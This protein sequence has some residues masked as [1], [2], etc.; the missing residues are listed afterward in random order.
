MII[1]KGDT[2]EVIEAKMRSA[3][4]WQ[5]V[6]NA[7]ADMR[8]KVETIRSLGLDPDKLGVDIVGVGSSRDGKLHAVSKHGAAP[9]DD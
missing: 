6:G 7:V 1:R 8:R 3:R 5:A 2:P 9:K 4:T